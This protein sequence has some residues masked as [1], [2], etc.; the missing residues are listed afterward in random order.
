MST[1]PSTRARSG[2]G[3]SS[4]SANRSANN[5]MP[6][7]LGGMGVL[8]V[9]G[10]FF[11]M[12]GGSK[13]AEAAPTAVKAPAASVPAATPAP[14]AS[15]KLDLAGA[16]AGKAPAKPAPALAAATLQQVHDLLGEAKGI[17]NEGVTLRVNGDNQQARDKQTAARDKIEAAK[18]LV[19][20]P[21]LWQEEADMEGWAMPAEYVT[22]TNL[23]G[24][25]SRLE[26]KIRMNG[27]S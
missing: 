15:S 16:K 18:K 19:A 5:S 21:L 27:G 14:A 2:G 7:I 9:V 3:R 26:K 10:V 13:P 8:V 22:L 20:T 25:M 17:S 6:L 12:R 24:E 11:M 1:R 23:F 4:G